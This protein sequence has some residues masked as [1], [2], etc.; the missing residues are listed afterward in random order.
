MQQGDVQSSGFFLDRSEVDCKSDWA[1]VIVKVLNMLH[2]RRMSQKF[3]FYF[4]YEFI[5]HP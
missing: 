3:V 4:L 1:E 5:G 2:D